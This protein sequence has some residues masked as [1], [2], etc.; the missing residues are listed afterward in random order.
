MKGKNIY[1]RV[2]KFVSPYWPRLLVA[3]ICMGGVSAITAAFALLTKNVLDDVFINKDTFMLKILPLGLIGLGMLKGA[4]NFCQGYFMNYVGQRVVAD[5]RERLYSHLQTLSL[6][7]FDRTPTGV[8]MARITNDV[9]SVQGAVSNAVTGMIKDFFTAAGLIGVIFYRDWQM[10]ILAILVFPLATYPFIRFGRKLRKVSKRTLETM[11]HIST[12]LQETIL[13]HRIVKA[14]NMED[15]ESRRF[16]EANE[17][18]LRYIMKRVKVRALSTPVMECLAYLGIGSFI[19]FGGYSVINGRMTVGDFFSFMTA[20]AL[21]YDPLKG[22]SKVNLLIQE[23]IAAAQRVFAVL[24]LKP[25][26]TDAPD[27]LPLASFSR[28]IEYRDVSFRYDDEMVLKRISFKVK[29]GEKVALVGSSGAGKTTLVNLLPR[30]YDATEGQIL[31]DGV[32]IHKVTLKSL[33][34]Q[35][36]VVAQQTLLFNDTVRSNIAYGRPDIPEEEV[37][38]AAKMADAHDFIIRLPQGYDTIIGEQGVRLSGGQRQRISIARALLKN[39]P[40]LI[41]DEATSSLDTESEREVQGALD[42]LMEKRTVLVIAHRLSTVRNV[43]RTLVLSEGKI[44]EE[45]PHKE[46]MAVGGEYKKLYELQFQD[47]DRPLREVV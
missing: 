22:L 30:F 15:Y 45:G 13:G 17:R 46:L 39:A 47:E 42:R 1:L 10:A 11:A 35:I 41:L 40:I 9:A 27:A 7:F 19:W 6:S 18:Y 4:F 37:I 2:L 16:A 14:F 23:G 20:L 12:F 36:G 24:D 31:I 38:M 43:D 33:R 8:L 3:M 44:V 34:D 21:L 28:K 25:E 26:V 29:A 5:I 32:D